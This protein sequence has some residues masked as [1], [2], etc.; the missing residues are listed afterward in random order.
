[1]CW[2]PWWELCRRFREHRS[3]SRC[4]DWSAVC[5]ISFSVRLAAVEQAKS[6]V[7]RPVRSC[8]FGLPAAGAC[9]LNHT[10]PC[11]RRY[12]FRDFLVLRTVGGRSEFSREVYSVRPPVDKKYPVLRKIGLT[13]AAR[14]LA[15]GGGS[16]IETRKRGGECCEQRLPPRIAAMRL[17]RDLEAVGDCACQRSSP[18][19]PPSRQLE[20]RKQKFAPFGP[21]E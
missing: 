9:A 14:C 16:H 21:G 12:A 3:P 5:S 20:A 13:E 19:T 15:C 1:M 10:R 11:W 6:S 7:L 17:S 8:R 2:P 4:S 18:E